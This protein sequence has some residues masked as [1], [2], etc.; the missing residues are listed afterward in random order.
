M[1]HALTSRA[2]YRL[3]VD[4]VRA[5]SGEQRYAEYDGV[6]VGSEADKYKLTYERYAG[7]NAGLLLDMGIIN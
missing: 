5:S 2:R 7:G 1:L 4:L 3:R 6:V